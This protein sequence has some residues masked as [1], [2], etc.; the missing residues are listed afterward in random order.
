MKEEHASRTAVI[1]CQGRAAA[2]GRL[3]PERFHDDAAIALLRGD[4]R[5]PVETVRSGTPP[6]DW[7][8][9]IAYEMV[10]GSAEVI[11]ARSV[12]IDDAVRARIS[13]QL[14]IL[15][16]GLDDRAYRMPELAAVDVFEVDHPASQADKR[17]RLDRGRLSPVAASARFVPVD[18]TRDRLA[19]ALAAA[20]HSPAVA[21]TWIWEG[22]V[23]Y[24]TK[25]QVDTTAAAVDELAAPGSRFV[26]NYQVPAATAVLGRAAAR[27]M[28][29]LARQ[30]DLWA[31]EP[32]RSSWTP[33]A[34]RAL[35]TRHH[36][37]VSEEKDLLT[38]ATRLGIPIK[39]PRSLRGGWITVADK[40]RAGQSAGG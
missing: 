11:V 27:V 35:L 33:D 19:D 23:P 2:A 17:D 30:P 8:A 20:G 39:Q 9:R 5:V 18:F 28:T 29:T 4:E 6:K 12:G 16:A 3:A 36:F 37:A 7:G 26:V 40:P 21:T 1:V 34:M 24:L 15:G 10:R 31:T 22:V 13:P 32:H 25:D 38:I 14:V